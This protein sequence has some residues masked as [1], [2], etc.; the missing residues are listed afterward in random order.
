MFD[1]ELYFMQPEDG[2]RKFMCTDVQVQ[3]VMNIIML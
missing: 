1:P 2:G 3:F